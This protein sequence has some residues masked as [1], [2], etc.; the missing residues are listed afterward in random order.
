[1]KPSLK[2]AFLLMCMLSSAAWGQLEVGGSY[3]HLTGNSGLDGVSGSAGWQWN[4]Y[5]TLVGEVN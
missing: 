5:V 3:S 1:M 2:Y 4:Q